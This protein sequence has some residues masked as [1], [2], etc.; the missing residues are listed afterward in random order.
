MPKRLKDKNKSVFV[1][2]HQDVTDKEAMALMSSIGVSGTRVSTLIKRWVVEVPYWKEDF[3]C[4][5]MLRSELVE[6]IHENFDGKRRFQETRNEEED[7]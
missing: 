6:T 7:E 4:E 3:Y 2:F 1:K 5:R